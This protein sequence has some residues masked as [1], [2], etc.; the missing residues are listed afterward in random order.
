MKLSELK[1][2]ESATII[3]IDTDGEMKKRLVDLG[4]N[5]GTLIKLERNAPLGDPQE[6]HIDMSSF[7]IR[8]KDAEKIIVEKIN[9]DIKK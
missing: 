2:G 4:I 3:K 6:F 1:R 7:A 9:G 5:S 8:K